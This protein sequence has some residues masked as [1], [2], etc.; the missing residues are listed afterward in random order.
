MITS[1]TSSTS[2]SSA[3]KKVNVLDEDTYISTLETI[4]QR[5]FFP[6]LPKLRQQNEWLE[7]AETGD[8]E[9]M[10]K[11]Q[12]NIQRSSVRGGSS[13]VRATPSSNSFE[14][15]SSGRMATPSRGDESSHQHQQ[16]QRQQHQQQGGGLLPE[17]H[18]SLN[19]FQTKY[20]SE[21]NDSFVQIMEAETEKHKKKYA[22]LYEMEEKQRVLRLEGGSAS[23]SPSPSSST[24]AIT[25][26][27]GSPHAQ[28]N[29]LAIILTKPSTPS[30][31][32]SSI[33]SSSNESPRVETWDYK[34]KNALMYTPEGVDFTLEELINERTGPPPQIVHNNTRLPED[35]NDPNYG[36]IA[37][38]LADMDKEAEVIWQMLDAGG[39]PA[40]AIMNAR[41][42][43]AMAAGNGGRLPPPPSSS[44]QASMSITGSPRVNGYG[45]V[46]TPSPS[47]MMLGG[48]TPVRT[49]ESDVGGPKFRI[50]DTPGREKLA[51]DLVDRKAKERSAKKAMAL[52][53]TNIATPKRLH[54]HT[55][56][57]TRTPTSS[58]S[59]N[60]R[61]STFADIQLRATYA[62]PTASKKSSSGAKTPVLSSGGGGS[63]NR[64]LSSASPGVDLRLR[65]KIKLE[66]QSSTP[67]IKPVVVVPSSSSKSRSTSDDLSQR[68]I[69]NQP[70]LPTTSDELTDNLLNI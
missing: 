48:Q 12:D 6:D 33:T 13:S 57:A 55:P 3:K 20:T 44:L 47:P 60:V 62:S 54:P 7:A 26:S 41:R 14:T 64:R 10:R 19:T 42:A 25:S 52:A 5:D 68:P 16:Q 31:S 36:H 53:A 46:L 61:S 69:A 21:D 34:A 39:T 17:K 37:D 43:A 65:K 63:S 50:P 35:I 8:I 70:S 40:A 15:P 1:A 18:I 66:P 49:S 45:F 28:G 30:Q 4:I 11:I 29:Q 24:L 38:P 2:A 59:P 22:W 27:S 58:A 9:K 32:P 51:M 23:S 67:N 56:T